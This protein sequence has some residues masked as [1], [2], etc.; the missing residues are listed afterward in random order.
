MCLCKFANKIIL[1]Q[2]ALQFRATI[3]FS[4]SQQTI[5]KIM[6]HVPPLL[7]WHI[8]QIIVYVLSGC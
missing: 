3:V 2:E 5:V 8:C 4:Y 1:F 6:G 7:T